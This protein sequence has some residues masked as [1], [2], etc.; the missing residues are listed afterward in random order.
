M[1]RKKKP[2]NWTQNIE[3]L[4]TTE[5]LNKF[6]KDGM[7]EKVWRS[8]RYHYIKKGCKKWFQEGK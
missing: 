7:L 3:Y 1:G 8:T 4:F 2:L 5:E 6:V